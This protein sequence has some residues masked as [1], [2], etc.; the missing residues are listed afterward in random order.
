MR[1]VIARHGMLVPDDEA[2]VKYLAARG[3]GEVVNLR[4]AVEQ[5]RLRRFVFAMLRD[6]APLAPRCNLRAYLA[7]RTGYGEI[8]GHNHPPIIVPQSVS[9][10]SEAEFEAFWED[11]RAYILT[12]LLP[13]PG[14]NPD[15][16]ALRETLGSPNDKALD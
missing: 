7:M 5:S 1:F 16:D 2:S 11:A 6:L 12:S 9:D 15:A 13:V 8:V 3:P 14:Q 10:M 4:A